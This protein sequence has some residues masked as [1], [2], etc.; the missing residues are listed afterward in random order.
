MKKSDLRS[1]MIITLRNGSTFLLVDTLKCGLLGI[2]NNEYFTLTFQKEDLTHKVTKFRDIIKIQEITYESN[3]HFDNW[4]YAPEIWNESTRKMTVK[5]I[6][7][8][9][10]Y[11]VEIVE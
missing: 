2:N 3:G 9:L 10:G 5:E 4:K 8:I 1:G 7:Q 6:S 11:K